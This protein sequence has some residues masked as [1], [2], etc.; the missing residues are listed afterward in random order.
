GIFYIADKLIFVDIFKLAKEEHVKLELHCLI[1][2]R[3]V[4]GLI[5]S[6]NFNQIRPDIYESVNLYVDV[7]SKGVETRVDVSSTTAD[8]GWSRMTSARTT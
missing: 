3:P 6:L 1:G 4:R 2:T 5:K 8:Y 7:F